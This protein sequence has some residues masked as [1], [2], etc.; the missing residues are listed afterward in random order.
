MI[1]T[2]HSEDRKPVYLHDGN[3]IHRH[4]WNERFNVHTSWNEGYVI[5]D[6]EILYVRRHT[7]EPQWYEIPPDQQVMPL[8]IMSEEILKARNATSDVCHDLNTLFGDLYTHSSLDDSLTMLTHVENSLD[9]VQ[10]RLEGVE[11]NLRA[12]IAH[13]K[14]S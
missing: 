14:L 6:D 13:S 4:I 3:L 5:F 10:E 9:I 12:I 11:M 8:M 7:I 2:G 1:L